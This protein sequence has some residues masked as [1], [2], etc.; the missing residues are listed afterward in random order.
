MNKIIVSAL[1]LSGMAANAQQQQV[2]I[3]T[4]EPKATLH[5]EAGASENK[6]VIIPRITAAEMKTMTAGLGADHHSMMTYLKEQ[7][8]TADRT[9]KLADVTEPGY[10]FYDNTTGV[11]KWKALGGEQDF[12]K[13][14]LDNYLTKDAGIGG[15]GTSL[16]TGDGSIGIGKY[17][18]GGFASSNDLTGRMNIALGRREKHSHGR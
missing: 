11:Q 13:V 6:G 17:T 15:N 2:G 5:V 7:M 9:G 10:Y 1:L 4:A 18:F 12:R 3:N 14:W 8:P 16:G